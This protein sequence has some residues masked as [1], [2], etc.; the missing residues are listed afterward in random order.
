[1]FRSVR[2][3]SLAS[4]WLDSEQDLSE[5]L[6]GAVFKP[7]GPYSERSSGFEPPT[8]DDAQGLVRRVGGA[9]LLRLR[10]QAR[11]LPAAA[12]NEAFE[13]RLT[14]YRARMQQE[15]GRRTK[16]QL[17]EQT[18]DELLPKALLKSERTTALVILSERVLALGSA[19]QSRA[20]RFLEQLRA[21]LGTLEVTPLEFKRPFGELL[22]Q[23]FLGDAPR[24]FVL[25]R[26]CR[27]RDPK[28]ASSTVRWTN[29][30]LAHSTVQRCLRDGMEITHL[31][32]EF[33]NLLSG[34]LD[35][36]GALTKLALLGV[37][38]AP[39]PNG[40]D[41]A[42]AQQDAEI[43]LLGGT[44]RELLG[45]LRRTLGGE[46]TDASRHTVIGTTAKPVSVGLPDPS[47]ASA[48]SAPPPEALPASAL[49]G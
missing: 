39:T 26:E 19:S 12:L 3:Y 9:D 36:N 24:E 16:R 7:C 40:E 25:A 11:V 2:F 22:T 17:R 49:P 8:G 18:R 46:P 21:A 47:P 38:G 37:E 34:V 29:V 43:A 32:F 15:P 41:D 10:S 33:G 1:M 23:T 4:P 13:V 14:E 27:M 48:V 6:A 44:L 20:E 30:D 5:K 42:L 31:A 28:D 35:A 45:S